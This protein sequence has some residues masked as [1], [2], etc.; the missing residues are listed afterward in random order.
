MTDHHRAQTVEVV[1]EAGQ[2]RAGG[3]GEHEVLDPAEGDVRGERRIEVVARPAEG[4]ECLV[5]CL[6]LHGTRARGHAGERGRKRV[7]SAFGVDGDL[8]GVGL[9]HQAAGA[10]PL[11]EHDRG[12]DR[13]VPAEV[14]LGGGR[15]VTHPEGAMCFVPAGH[16]SRLGISDLRGDGEHLGIGQA[17]GVEGDA[18]GVAPFGVV[19]ESGVAQ[20]PDAVPHGRQT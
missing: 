4:G 17:G 18:R 9:E 6:F 7:A 15:E 5:E 10:E 14:D 2:P 11:G 20:N 16:E 3:G 19:G 8:T 13:G 1:V 12:G